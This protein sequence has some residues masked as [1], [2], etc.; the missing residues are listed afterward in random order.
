[1]ASTSRMLARN[2]L[3]RPSPLLAPSPSPPMSTTWTAACTSC[4][5]LLIAPSWS[6]RVSGTLAT[7]MFGSLVA[8]GY[9][10]A[11]APPPVSALYNELLPAFGRP[12][13]P[14]RSMTMARLPGSPSCSRRRCFPFRTAGSTQSIVKRLIRWFLLSLLGFG[15][16]AMCDGH[17]A[18]GIEPVPDGCIEHTTFG[19]GPDYAGDYRCAG[20]AIDY[21]RGGA[22][23]SPYPIWAGQWLFA[24]ENGAYRKGS[25]TFNR[26]I[27]PTIAGPSAL[28]AQDLPHDPTGAKSAYLTW[29]YGATTD[30]LTAAALWA[31]FHFYAQD[32]AG[33]NRSFVA[34]APLVDALDHVAEASGRQDVEDAAIRLD[35]EAEA[36]AEPFAVAVEIAVD[37]HGRATVTSGATPIAGTD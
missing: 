7:P 10:A 36:H 23:R 22:A 35:A 15:P 27:H 18:R 29:K 1:M 14:K 34:S 37:G 31:D 9:G 6:T 12:T 30:D 25:C 21:H 16:L 8:N 4:F 5:D 28:V 19:G 32:A 2:L 17:R 20:L 11:S 3:P 13:R 24:D 33:S 26:G